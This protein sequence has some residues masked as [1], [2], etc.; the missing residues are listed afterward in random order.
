MARICRS[1]LAAL[2]VAF[3]LPIDGGAA[4]RV[5]GWDTFTV[6]ETSPC[7]GETFEAEIRVHVVGTETN[8]PSG[9]LVSG[10]HITAVWGIG[11]AASGQRYLVRDGSNTSSLNAFLDPTGT[12][13]VFT[14]TARARVL[15]LGA[16]GQDYERAYVAHMTFTPDGRLVVS[17][18]PTEGVCR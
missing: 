18:E 5:E 11:T 6:T 16:D 4:L 8:T 14:A 13:Q 12:A 9:T 3:V 1:A 10:F 7:T 2:C 17:I 15:A